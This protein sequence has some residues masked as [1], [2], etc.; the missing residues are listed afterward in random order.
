MGDQSWLNS[1]SIGGVFSVIVAITTFIARMRRDPSTPSALRRM[2][3][4]TA[5]EHTQLQQIESLTMQLEQ[6]RRFSASKDKLIEMIQADLDKAVGIASSPGLPQSDLPPLRKR[7]TST[8]RSKRR[9]PGTTAHGQRPD[10]H[11]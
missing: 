9:L 2:W 3:I 11:P 10:A 7:P 1:W 8:R 5:T 6:E 4:W